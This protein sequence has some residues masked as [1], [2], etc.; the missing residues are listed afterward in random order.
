MTASPPGTPDQDP[1]KSEDP[2]L[3]ENATTSPEAGPTQAPKAPQVRNGYRAASATTPRVTI[4]DIARQAGVSKTAVSFA[5]NLPKRLSAETTQRIL[6]VARE[7]GYTPTPI[8]RSLNTRRTNAL[9]LLVPQDISDTLANPFFASLMS[10]IGQ[11]CKSEGL[12]LMMIPPRRGS[13]VDATYTALIDGCIA[14]GVD[15]DDDAVQVL[16]QRDIPFVMIDTDAPEGVPCVNIDDAEG[17]RLAMSHLLELGHRDIAI[18]AFES[19]FGTPEKYTGTLK[20]RFDGIRAA[21]GER[22][23]SL[24]QQ[25]I[26]TTEVPCTAAGGAQALQ[27]ILRLERRPTAVF[28]LGDAI[29]YGLIEAAFA[30]GLNVPGDLSVVGFD[31]IE[32]HVRAEPGLTT[33]RQSAQA[34]GRAAAELLMA[35]LRGEPVDNTRIT[36][37]IEFIQRGTTAP[38]VADA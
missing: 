17:A 13:L 18:V 16:R 4:K 15:A 9:G 32:T 3:S 33:V 8:A 19:F 22:G 30:H 21:L 27:R 12:S 34:K 7:L 23:I 2:A 31:D 10:G 1:R 37:P 28:A 36:V 14:T 29:A 26:Y 25:R 6:E 5:F 20:H 35:A 11:V 38:V 24:L